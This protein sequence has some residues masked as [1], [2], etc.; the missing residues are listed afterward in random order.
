MKMTSQISKIIKRKIATIVLVSASFAAFATLG[1]GSKKDNTPKNL[2]STRV[3]R[4]NYK[5]FSLRSG[6]SYRGSSVI[7]T[8][9]ESKY[10]FVE[11]VIT[12]QKGNQTYILPMKKKV[13]LDKVNFNPS[14][15]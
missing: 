10:F 11:R 1:E 8:S 7:N 12:Y 9:A 4:S 14:F 5:N 2:L 13:L 15:R 6:Y 3:A